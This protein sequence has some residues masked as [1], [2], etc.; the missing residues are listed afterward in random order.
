MLTI[1]AVIAAYAAGQVGDGLG[2]VEARRAVVEAAAEL[3][4]AASSLRRL[5]RLDRLDPAG[6][7]ALVADL[8]ASG[9]SHRRI[10]EAV[11]VAKRTVWG[12]LHRLATNEPQPGLTSTSPWSA[13]RAI[14]LRT[15]R[16]AV[17]SSSANATLE[18]RREP[19]G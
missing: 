14:A 19:G 10:A 4:A 1:T 16:G 8:A 12:D 6:R 2:P 7:R 17:P 11:G 9:W 18:G 15:V 3:E 13:S 5:A